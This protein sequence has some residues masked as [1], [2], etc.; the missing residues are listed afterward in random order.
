MMTSPLDPF[1]VTASFTKG[2]MVATQALN[3]GTTPDLSVN[4]D[5]TG[6]VS[7]TCTQSTEYDVGLSVGAF[8][9]TT[10]RMT[11]DKN[12]F[13]V[14]GLYRDAARTLGWGEAMGTMMSGVGTGLTESH[15]VYGRVMPQTAPPP[16][17]YNDRVVV[18][19]TY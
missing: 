11:N 1:S 8:T 2:C 12:E 4:V 16:G 17:T 19:I 15:V 18:T 9:P 10:R 6:Q 5:A 14:Y 3:F 7:V 13:V